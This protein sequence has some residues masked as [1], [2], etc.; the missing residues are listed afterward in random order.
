[1]V[2]ALRQVWEASDRLCA[3]RL[4][5]FLPDLVAVLERQ[6]ELTLTAEVR[7]QMVRR[8]AAT[9]DRHLRPYRCQGRPR[10][11]TQTRASSALRAQ[12]PVR[13]FGEWGDAR[14]G[15]L[16]A[17]LVAHG[18]ESTEGFYLSTLLAVDVATGW[19]EC[20]AVWGKGQQ[21]VGSAV[22]HLRQR[23]P[24]PLQELHTDNGGEFLNAVL[25]PYCQRAGI[26]LTRGRPSKKND[27]AYAEQKNWVVVRRLVGYDR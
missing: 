19:T 25:S 6:G 3:K 24:I 8:S 10:P 4:A 26:R 1:M 5:P 16:Q 12:V 15:A 14:P 2:D 23:L 21:R 27:Q 11:H 20:E 22:H 13:T 7:A 9:I 17:D 18:G